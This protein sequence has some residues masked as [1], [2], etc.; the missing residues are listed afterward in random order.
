[1][2]RTG[3]SSN[4]GKAFP[5]GFDQDL[6]GGVH[7]LSTCNC[8]MTVRAGDDS[9]QRKSVSSGRAAASRISDKKAGVRTQA[10]LASSVKS[11]HP[12]GLKLA[13][14]DAI[15]NQFGTKLPDYGF[16]RIYY[17]L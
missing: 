4:S 10:R 9:N 8:A 17:W 6:L 2:Q 12:G 16:W 11:P 15:W 14:N 13:R 5:Q 1:M 3:R 7:P